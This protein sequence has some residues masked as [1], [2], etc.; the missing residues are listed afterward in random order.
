MKIDT[1]AFELIRSTPSVA[2]FLIRVELD[3]PADG[4]EVTG[5]AIGPRCAGTSTVEVAYPLVAAGLSGKV[6]S[7]RCVIPEPNLWTPNGRFM[8]AITVEV[9]VNGEWT[10]ARSATM[11][12]RDTQPKPGNTTG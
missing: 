7:L 4:C 9:H 6:V 8:Y 10:D 2:E 1:I 3:G 11:A 5:R 12:F